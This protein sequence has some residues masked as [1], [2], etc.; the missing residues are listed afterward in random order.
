MLL[1]LSDNVTVKNG[2][3]PKTYTRKLIEQGLVDYKDLKIA[4]GKIKVLLLRKETIDQIVPSLIDKPVIIKH[5]DVDT[6]NFKELAVGY[7]KNI[8]FNPIDGW[9]Y[10]DFLITDDEGHQAMEDGWGVSCAYKIN[11]IISGGKYHNIDYE[12]EIVQGVGEHLALVKNPRYEDCLTVV[13]GVEC[14]LY[15]EKSYLTKN[16]QEDNTMLFNFFGKKDDK[17]FKPDTLVDLGNGKTAPLGEIMK[18]ANSILSKEAHQIDGTVEIELENGKKVKLEDAIKAFNAA[19]DKGETADEKAAREKEEGKKAENAVK[20]KNCACGGEKDGKHMESCKMY[21]ADGSD[22]E[23]K[24]DKMENATLVALQNDVKAVKLEN[25]AL[26]EAIKNNGIFVKINTLKD[27]SL[28]NV[29]LENSTKESG[30]I[31]NRLENAKQY[32]VPKTK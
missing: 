8:Y 6:E 24:D 5:Q 18:I 21:N 15:N 25:E 13:N 14:L 29:V 16:Q 32:F 20:F 12:G 11:Q 26:K 1:K 22:K 4:G 23:K 10:V 2:Q 3:W 31:E 9:Y 28:E 30:T 7:I 19:T 17:G 27:A